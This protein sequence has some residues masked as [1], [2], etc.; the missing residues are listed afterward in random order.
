MKMAPVYS[1]DGRLLGHLN[2]EVCVQ[3][4]YSV[5]VENS[6]QAPRAVPSFNHADLMNETIEIFHVQFR[7][8]RF[9][10]GTSEQEVLCLVANKLPDWFWDAYP[11]L[12]FSSDHWERL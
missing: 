5:V 9:R 8:L 6:P 7:K 11:T 10:F 12:K 2:M 4:H 1:S 3:T